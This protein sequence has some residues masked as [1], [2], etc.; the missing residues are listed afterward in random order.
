[1]GRDVGH[2][3]GGGRPLHGGQAGL[4][5]A[6]LSAPGRA[7]PGQTPGDSKRGAH[8]PDVADVAEDF[9]A[10]PLDA[11]GRDRVLEKLDARGVRRI[12][13]QALGQ[14]ERAGQI[15]GEDEVLV[16]QVEHPARLARAQRL[17]GREDQA[18][19]EGHLARCIRVAREVANALAPRVERA[20]DPLLVDPNREADVGRG[21]REQL[22]VDAQGRLGKLVRDEVDGRERV[23]EALHEGHVA[24]L[25]GDPRL[26]VGVAVAVEHVLRDDVGPGPRAQDRA[27]GPLAGLGI[28]PLLD[29]GGR[30]HVAMDEPR[31]LARDDQFHLAAVREVRERH[32]QDAVEAAAGGFMKRPVVYE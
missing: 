13:L 22:Q 7:E 15:P 25:R 32:G 5:R 24:F 10:P 26:S 17:G 30:E 12:V 29:P 27:P 4:R 31:L 21:L 3:A 14:L 16:G 23:E 8:E 20:R 2:A 1:M 6:R 28:P 18:L 9:N 11:L 19:D